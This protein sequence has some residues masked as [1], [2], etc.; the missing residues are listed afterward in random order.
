MQIAY[1]SPHDAAKYESPPIDAQLLPSMAQGDTYLSP[2]DSN[3]SSSSAIYPS[4]V[5]TANNMNTNGATVPESILAWHNG[6]KNGLPSMDNL[7]VLTSYPDAMDP[8]ETVQGYHQENPT[9][10]FNLYN[11]FSFPSMADDNLADQ[12]YVV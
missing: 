3:N 2:V 5:D 1:P 12:A 9:M 7:A 4:F 11:D 8:M 10:D 6:L